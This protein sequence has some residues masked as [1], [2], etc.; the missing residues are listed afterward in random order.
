MNNRSIYD[1]DF[2]NGE[3][4]GYGQSFLDGGLVYNGEFKEGKMKGKAI[5]YEGSKILYEGEFDEDD[6]KYYNVSKFLLYKIKN[7]FNWK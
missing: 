6:N 7:I 2:K 1:G 5:I 4:H 3:P